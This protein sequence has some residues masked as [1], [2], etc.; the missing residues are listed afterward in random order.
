MAPGTTKRVKVCLHPQP[1]KR[2]AIW[3]PADLHFAKIKVGARRRFPGVDGNPL[4]KVLRHPAGISLG[5]PV[6]S[7]RCPEF[8]DLPITAVPPVF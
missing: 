2:L 1:W 4:K 7:L 8:T 3:S 6:S 5:D